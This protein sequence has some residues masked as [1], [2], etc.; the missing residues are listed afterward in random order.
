[1]PYE[2]EIQIDVARDWV[3]LVTVEDPNIVYEIRGDKEGVV[4]VKLTDLVEQG[5]ARAVGFPEASADIDPEFANTLVV[6][7]KLRFT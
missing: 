2:A 5:L 1:M 4:Q 3:E 6:K 7:E